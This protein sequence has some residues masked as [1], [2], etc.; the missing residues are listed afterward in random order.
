MVRTVELIRTQLKKLARVVGCVT[1]R[2]ARCP[3]DFIV[4]ITCANYVTF[5]ISLEFKSISS[6]GRK[7]VSI[8]PHYEAKNKLFRQT[9]K[10]STI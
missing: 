6:P 10:N 1:N 3:N 8:D 9:F 2:S 7:N 4:L 5:L